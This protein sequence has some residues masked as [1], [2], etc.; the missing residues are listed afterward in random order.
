[1]KPLLG[2]YGGKAKLAEQIVSLFPPHR[3][4]CE[5]F[6]GMAACLMAKRPSKTEIYNDLA[7]ELVNLFEVIRTQPDALAASLALTPYS[8]VEF[9]RCGKRR[10]EEGISPL[11]RARCTY[12]VLSQ[13]R[14]NS[15]LGRSWSH[16][17]PK[18][19]G[20]VV[21]TYKAGFARIYEVAK[22]LSNVML[23]NRPAVQL[24]SEWAGK[25]VLLYV[26]PPYH[27][28]TRN[29]KGYKF[30]MSHEA[31]EE[32]VETLLNFPGFVILSG[33]QHAVYEPL[34]Q[35]HWRKIEISVVAHSSA[36]HTSEQRKPK[37]V[38]CLWLNPRVAQ[39]NKLNLFSERREVA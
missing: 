21:Q 5:P 22:R 6:G 3:I 26:D 25:D 23:E 39:W 12:V 28:D 33:Y 29:A 24:I 8:R 13:G 11:E 9:Q 18:F 15:L 1:M 14:E 10:C 7:D 20:S 32:L 16:Q 17:G 30:E 2:Y 27:L 38:E 31:H 34:E 19:T 4:Y 35:A 37:R 36:A